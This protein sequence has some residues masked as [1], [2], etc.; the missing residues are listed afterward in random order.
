MQQRKN[1][2]GNIQ[3]QYV[4]KSDT[5]ESLCTPSQK[6]PVSVV[7]QVSVPQTSSNITKY[8]ISSSTYKNN[9]I[10]VFENKIMR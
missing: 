8:S 4:V 3:K 1:D 9:G 2:C 6:T 7:P 10:D 5:D